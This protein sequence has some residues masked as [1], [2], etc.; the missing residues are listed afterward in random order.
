MAITPGKDLPRRYFDESPISRLI[1]AKIPF[2]L[3]EEVIAQ[4][5]RFGPA[6]SVGLK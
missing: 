5:I 1:V 2:V 6:G 4:I 3:V